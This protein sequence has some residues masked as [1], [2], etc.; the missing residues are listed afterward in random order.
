MRLRENHASL[1]AASV[2]WTFNL[3]YKVCKYIG[4]NMT[5]YLF[6]FRLESG[7]QLGITVNELVFKAPN[8]KTFESAQRNTGEHGT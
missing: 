6:V 8:F 1:E 5:N 3:L 4:D 7:S 2:N